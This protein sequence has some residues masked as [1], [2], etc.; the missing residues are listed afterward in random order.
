MR[1]LAEKLRAVF[2]EVRGCETLQMSDKRDDRQTKHNLHRHAAQYL[3]AVYLLAQPDEPAHTHL[4]WAACHLELAT[5]LFL[6]KPLVLGELLALWYHRHL[7]DPKAAH[8][9]DQLLFWTTNPENNNGKSDD[10]LNVQLPVSVWV[11]G[12]FNPM[13]FTNF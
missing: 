3:A 9:A 11:G 12:L 1:A 10:I 5:L 6:K 8:R 7:A 4:L 2:D 13:S